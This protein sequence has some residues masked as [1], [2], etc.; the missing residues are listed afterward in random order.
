[1]KTPEECESITDIRAEIDR[2]DRQIVALLGERLRYA[3]AASRFKTSEASVRA[4]ERVRNLLE[5]RR[6][7][8]A[9][10]GLDPEVIEK[11]YRD[12]L[13]FFIEEEMND[14][15]ASKEQ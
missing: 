5:Q 13:I 4:V 8:A 6:A 15:K 14:W 7:W 1:M 11:M 9:E 2:R 3:R 12:L 10:E